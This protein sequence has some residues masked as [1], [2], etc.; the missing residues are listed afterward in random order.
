MKQVL[1]AFALA[2]AFGWAAHAEDPGSKTPDQHVKDANE[3]VENG[4]AVKVETDH[5]VRPGA[6]DAMEHE[7]EMKTDKTKK[8][9]A[10]KKAK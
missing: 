2:F 6:T 5:T 4:G 8:K 9:K 3:K 7:H 10:K 1:L